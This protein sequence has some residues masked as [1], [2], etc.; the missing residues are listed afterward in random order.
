MD[1]GYRETVLRPRFGQVLAA[2]VIAICLVAVIGFA[3]I[4]DTAALLRGLFPL[5]LGAIG[6]LALFWRPS[7]RITPAELVLT[8]P[9]RTVRITW[10]AVQEIETQWSLIVTAGDRRFSAWAAPRESAMSSGRR[11]PSH[12]HGT[13]GD[14]PAHSSSRGV[15]GNG[16]LAG[17]LAA[18]QWQAY[19]DRGL[20]GAVEGT[21]VE[22]HWHGRTIAVLVLLAVGSIASTVALQ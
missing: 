12:A 9:F 21:G 10:P 2:A 5:A 11:R 20:L 16:A 13:G 4:G 1:F 22:V 15:P 14:P 19:R 8:N 7:V 17:A 3:L 6:S 18:R